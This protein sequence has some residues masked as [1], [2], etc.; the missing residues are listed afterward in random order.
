MQLEDIRRAPRGRD[1]LVLGLSLP[2]IFGIVGFLVY[3]KLD[4]PSIAVGIWGF[5]TVLSLVFALVRPVRGTIYRAWMYAVFP[6]GWTVTHVVMALLF[7]AVITP[8]GLLLR[9]FGHDALT[10]RMD[11]KAESYWT[12]RPQPS[13][14]D[15]YFQQY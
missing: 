6:I 10:R 14:I 3:S 13:S 12:Q 9:L 5:G 15:R 1:L 8:V 7:F 4:A 2:L 11:S